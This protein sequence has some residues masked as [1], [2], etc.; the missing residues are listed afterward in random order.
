MTLTKN[1]CISVHSCHFG[2]TRIMVASTGL[3]K[4]NKGCILSEYLSFGVI[5]YWFL[6][7]ILAILSV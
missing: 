2:N 6:I 3:E 5:Q 4:K 7:Q 1:A